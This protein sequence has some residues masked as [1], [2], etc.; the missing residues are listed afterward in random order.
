VV[1]LVAALR[2]VVDSPEFPR[3]GV[4]RQRLDVAVA[5]GEQEFVRLPVP[6]RV[7][8][9]RLAR[10]G[11]PQDAAS[12]ILEILR[13]LEVPTLSDRQE[14]HPVLA[15]GHSAAEVQSARVLVVLLHD[16]D[17]L[18]L[19]KRGLA[20]GPDAAL[21]DNRRAALG[22]AGVGPVDI[23]VLVEIRVQRDVEQAG[24]T[25]PG[26][27]VVAKQVLDLVHDVRGGAVGGDEPNGARI[28]FRHQQPLV[29][30]ES[31]A[32]GMFEALRDR[33]DLE[34]DVVGLDRADLLCMEGKGGGQC[35][36][37]E[38]KKALHV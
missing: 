17:V 12:L 29:G 13:A 24:L 34:R 21:D 5:R 2:S 19:A 3:F 14:Q 8:A 16:P 20:V 6:G 9:G 30:K 26:L 32:P 7:V 36:R 35:G 31:E 23:P 11:H 33:R 1:D 15:P 25:A 18:D 22:L 38:G 27:A 10:V 4:H 28:A 37:A